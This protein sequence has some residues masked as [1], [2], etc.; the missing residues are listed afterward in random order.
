MPTGNWTSFCTY[1]PDDLKVLEE[2]KSLNQSFSTL[3]LP[4]MVGITFIFLA[5]CAIVTPLQVYVV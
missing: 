5:Y 2:L 3:P 1:C 4:G